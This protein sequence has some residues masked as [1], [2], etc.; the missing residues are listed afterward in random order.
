MPKMTG[1][2]LIRE[3]RKMDEHKFTPILFLT[4]ES[5]VKLKQEAKE[6]GANGWIVKP[7]VPE[8]LI[9]A[10]NKVCT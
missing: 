1:V 6:A 8:K 5:D 9:F 2:E 7:F 3:I 4:T 10:I